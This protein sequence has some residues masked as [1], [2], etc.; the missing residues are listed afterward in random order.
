MANK[1]PIVDPLEI[2]AH[3]RRGKPGPWKPTRKPT[4]KTATYKP[5][6]P[7]SEDL[8]F[9]WEGIPRFRVHFT[10]VRGIPSGSR[11][12]HAKVGWKWVQI[13]VPGRITAVRVKREDWD[14]M[15]TE[16]LK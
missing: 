5:S 9:R 15:P 6:K 2:P 12:V 3:L 14:K 1:C 7:T 4:V 13:R 16:K 10:N 11:T 8:G